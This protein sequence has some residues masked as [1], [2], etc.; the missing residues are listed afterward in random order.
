MEGL[1]LFQEPFEPTA[2][3]SKLTELL[4]TTTLVDARVVRELRSFN[5]AENDCVFE[6]C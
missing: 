3:E 1:D 6:S 2:F 5:K 4:E